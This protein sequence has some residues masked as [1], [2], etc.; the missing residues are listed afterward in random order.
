MAGRRVSQIVEPQS[1]ELRILANRPPASGEAV[2]TPAFRLSRKQ[3]RIGTPLPGKRFDTR[4]CGLAERHGAGSG[5]AIRQLD[6]LG[7]DVAP[8]KI[9]HLA[10]PASG[11]RQQPNSG[12]CLGSFGLAGVERAAKPLQLVRIEEPGDLAARVLADTETGIAVALAPA[13]F[14]GRPGE[15]V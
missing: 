9:E 10:T 15:R 6:G 4:P 13:P 1:A 11:E 5:L 14:L 12:D 8:A 3:E 7:P 2:L